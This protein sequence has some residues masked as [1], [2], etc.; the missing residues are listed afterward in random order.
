MNKEK[1][2][3]KFVKQEGYEHYNHMDVL[4]QFFY[5]GFHNGYNKGVKKS[6][7]CIVP[8]GDRQSILS[9]VEKQK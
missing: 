6:A 1:L 7:K 5:A 4:R 2:F 3:Q 9:L 8:G